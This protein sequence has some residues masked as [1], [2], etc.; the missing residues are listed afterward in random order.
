MLQ[1]NNLEKNF[2][3]RTLFRNV[4]FSL[5]PGERLAIV[6]RNGTGKSTLFRIILGE[7][8]PEE[9]EVVHPRGY[10]IGHLSQHLSFRES[11]ILKEVCRGLPPGR[12]DEEYLGEIVLSGLGF[13]SADLER[14]AHSFSG[15][16]QIRIELAR[17][18]LSEPN[19][20]LLDEPTNYLDIVSARWLEQHLR[21]WPGEIMM[22]SHDRAFLDAVSTHTMII[23]RGGVRKVSGS[24]TKLYE[25]IK[26]DEEV[27]DKT[28]LNQEKKR[29]EMERFVERFKAK[30]GT[31]ALAQSRA[32]MLEKM[33]IGEELQEE[34]AL[35]FTFT[36]APFHGKV[37]LSAEGISFTYPKTPSQPNPAQI[38]GSFNLTI[39]HGDRI[40]IIGKNGRGKS[41]LLRLLADDLKPNS[42]E[43]KSSPHARLGYFGQTNIARLTPNL[44]IEDEIMQA[45]LVGASRSGVD[46]TRIRGICGTMMF[47]GDDALKQIRVLSGG[48]K[49]RV[50]LGKLLAQPTNLLLLDEPTNHL[51]VESVAALVDSLETF[52]G[53]VLLV[54]HDEFM[55]RRLARKIVLFADNGVHLIDGGYDYF[56]EKFGWGDGDSLPPEGKS[57]PSATPPQSP[58]ETKREKPRSRSTIEREISSIESKIME[59]EAALKELQSKLLVESQKAQ[60]E[61]TA[62]TFA[63]Y[64]K[65]QLQYEREIEELFGELEILSKKS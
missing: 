45:A 55:L 40:A 6:G 4:S 35:D 39:T 50:L 2:G 28:R 44:T 24:T 57:T 8:S 63:L 47:S 22:I 11:N 52:Q 18:L 64:S 15:G 14:P 1:V 25:L 46:R 59:K 27:Y 41:T 49:S 16:F 9:G 30:A 17:V 5:T 61:Q 56:L 12:E 42:G 53:A 38:L 20:L 60:N 21:D 34:P 58:S 62:Q 13:S 51:D 19:L 10:K 43:I 36:A 26:Q 29:R 7:E 65:T 48:E 31:A 32:K 23:H 54:T 37:L 3:D 33:E